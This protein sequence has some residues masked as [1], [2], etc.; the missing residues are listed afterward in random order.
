MAS[1]PIRTYAR[2]RAFDVECPHCGALYVVKREGKTS[3]RWW[4]PVRSELRCDGCNRAYVVGLALWKVNP[5]KP[6]K[7]RPLDQVP[8][9]RTLQSLRG[10]LAGHARRD[11]KGRTARTLALIDEAEGEQ[12]CTCQRYPAPLQYLKIPET[13]QACAVHGGRK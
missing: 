12:G 11:S 4:D 3:Y 2:P 8:T 6:A 9:R 1:D 5:G 13:V 7:G 10:L